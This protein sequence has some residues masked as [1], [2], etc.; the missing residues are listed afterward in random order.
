[1]LSTPPL[2]ATLAHA[3]PAACTEHHAWLRAEPGRFVAGTIPC[4]IMGD[5]EEWT[6]LGTCPACLSTIGIAVSLEVAR[7][8]AAV[9]R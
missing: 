9:K 3:T 6:Y 5:D 7:E 4:G 1:M 8:L 2:A